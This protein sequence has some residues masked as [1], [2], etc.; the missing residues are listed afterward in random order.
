[1]CKGEMIINEYGIWY[2]YEEIVH[3]YHEIGFKENG[4]Y[5]NDDFLFTWEELED[6]KNRLEVK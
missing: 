2:D 4:M 3:N 6:I 5:F 1:M